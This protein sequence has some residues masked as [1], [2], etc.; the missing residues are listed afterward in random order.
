MKSKKDNTLVTVT[1]KKQSHRYR[2]R[3]SGYQWWEGRGEGQARERE[4]Q[5]IR[6]P[7]KIKQ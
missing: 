4:L 1:K 6:I 7:Y 2:E 3:L 5:T